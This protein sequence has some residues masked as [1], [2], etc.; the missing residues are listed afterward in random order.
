MERREVWVL[1]AVAFIGG[2]AAGEL[3]SGGGSVDTR[4]VC[5]VVGG[6]RWETETAHAGPDGDHWH[7]IRGDGAG[8]PRAVRCEHL[9]DRRS[10]TEAVTSGLVGL[11]ALALLC[12]LPW[13]LAV[14]AS[15]GLRRSGVLFRLG[16]WCGRRSRRQRP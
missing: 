5:E 6:A 8:A 10:P 16:R 4:H 7:E 14:G 9:P 15:D 3:L 11:A 12:W 1:L 2:L 13:Y